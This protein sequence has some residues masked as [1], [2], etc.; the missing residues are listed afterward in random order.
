MAEEIKMDYPLI[1]EMGNTFQQGRQQLQETLKEAQN[2]ASTLENGA[3]LGQAG[4]A[5]SDAIRS[6]LAPSIQRLSQKFEELQL[7]LRVAEAAMKQ[8]ESDTKASFAG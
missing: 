7:D 2:I 4:S 1:E 3:L 8:A 6:K 5:F